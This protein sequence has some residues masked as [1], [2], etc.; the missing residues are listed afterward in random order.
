MFSFKCER[1]CIPRQKNPSRTFLLYFWG[2][3]LKQI[4]Y[5]KAES[6]ADLIPCSRGWTWSCGLFQSSIES[7]ARERREGDRGS[8]KPQAMKNKPDA[9]AFFEEI[10]CHRNEKRLFLKRPCTLAIKNTPDWQAFF[11]ETVYPS[12]Q[13]YP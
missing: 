8:L 9:Q 1:V 13:K 2:I 3:T 11:E 12:N 7:P 4:T 10:V 6:D 5:H